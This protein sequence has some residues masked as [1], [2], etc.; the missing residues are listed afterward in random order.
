MERA[1]PKIV[2]GKSALPPV[3]GRPMDLPTDGYTFGAFAPRMA[4]GRVGFGSG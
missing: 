1:K 4:S 2:F 3:V